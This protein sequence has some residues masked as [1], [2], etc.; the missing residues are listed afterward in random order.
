[1]TEHKVEIPS[2]LRHLPVVGGY[3]VPWVNARINGKW[4]FATLDPRKVARA[5]TDSLCAICGEKLTLFKGAR[6]AAGCWFI[7]GPLSMIN[8]AFTDPPMHEECARFCLKTCPHL[9]GDIGFRKLH[10]DVEAHAHAS[11]KKVPFFG[12]ARSSGCVVQRL[13]GG[14]DY[15]IRSFPWADGTQGIEWHKNGE[16]IYPTWEEV[17]ATL[18]PNLK[19]AMPETS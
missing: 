3:P 11:S 15:F 6:F 17:L 7:G 16:R 18:G 8:R 14:T 1:M 9:T 19:L 12:L 10:D 2:H 13:E 4:D 5:L